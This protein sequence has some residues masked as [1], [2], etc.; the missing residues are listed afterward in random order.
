MFP[1]RPKNI[2]KQQ[3]NS[4]TIQYNGLVGIQRQNIQTLKTYDC[5]ILIKEK[6]KKKEDSI[7][8]GTDYEH[9]RA[10]YYLTQQ[11]RISNNS[12]ITIK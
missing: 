6:S 9:Q 2:L 1:L 5:P 8:V 10:K 7:E 11:H 12:S 4:S 3:S